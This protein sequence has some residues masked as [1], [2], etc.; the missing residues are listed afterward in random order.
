[1][2]ASK[3]NASGSPLL[4]VAFGT[5]GADQKELRFA[6]PFRIGRTEESEVCVKDDHVSRN[7]AEVFFEG[8]NW[9]IRDLN[10]TNG[11]YVNGQ[12]FERLAVN[13]TLT[14]RLGVRGP[15][16]SLR[17][18]APSAEMENH[19]DDEAVIAHFI[20]HYFRESAAGEPVGRHT[21][22]V[23]KAFAQVQ[24]QQK[25]R[26]RYVVGT[27]LVC[28]LAAGTYGIYEHQQVKM[29]KVMA[30]DL[31]YAMKAIDVDI[32]NLEK[33]A[34]SSHDQQGIEVIRK[35]EDQ[36]NEMQRKY[37]QF[38]A[39]LHVYNPKLTDQQKLV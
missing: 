4:H 33:T 31:F 17:A 32:A 16:V 30:K 23:R 35:E 20:K 25:R 24:N 22:F 6:K 9:W 39:T 5:A 21:M 37:D 26:Y 27:L 11:V 38:L 8:G 14:I 12:R 3:F 7:H 2:K 36:R 10:S 34:L 1:M 15:E 13:G 19:A 28:V 29:Q 18:E